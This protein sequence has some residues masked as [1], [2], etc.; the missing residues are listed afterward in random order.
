[1]PL[2]GPC[3]T[4]HVMTDMPRGSAG[5]NGRAGRREPLGL[6]ERGSRPWLGLRLTPDVV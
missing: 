6:Q 4:C 1:M 2:P 5:E 3:P